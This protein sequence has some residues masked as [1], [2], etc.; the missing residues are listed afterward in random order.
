[1]RA[2]QEV[3]DSF[4]LSLPVL[5]A[6]VPGPF[7]MLFPSP[8]MFFLELSAPHKIFAGSLAQDPHAR[9]SAV[10]LLSPPC[11]MVPRINHEHS[12]GC[13]QGTLPAAHA[14]DLKY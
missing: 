12:H 14:R 9:L 13:G 11:P 1:M 5:P 2:F 3:P 8:R 10:T 7:H 4:H 6:S